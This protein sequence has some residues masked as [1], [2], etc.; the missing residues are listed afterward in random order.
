MP[1]EPAGAPRSW[2]PGAGRVV[3]GSTEGK[4]R[5][6]GGTP[7]T[8]RSVVRSRG[9]RVVLGLT[10]I[11]LIYIVLIQVLFW[12]QP[13]RPPNLIVFQAG[14]EAELAVD[15]NA[16]GLNAAASLLAEIRRPAANLA[17]RK[18]WF[19][20]STGFAPKVE[21]RQLDPPFVPTTAIPA[22]SLASGGSTILYITARVGT[23]EGRPYLL[24]Q[25][26]LD[27]NLR[28]TGL[29]SHI[30]FAE[31][32][33]ILEDLGVQKNHRF[34]LVLDVAPASV[35]DS[36]PLVDLHALASLERL[37]PGPHLVVILPKDARGT[38]VDVRWRQSVFGHHAIQGLLGAATGANHRLTPAKLAQ[39]I[40]AQINPTAAARSVGSV[41]IL[42]TPEAIHTDILLMS[43]SRGPRISESRLAV[44]AVWQ[45]QIQSTWKSYQALETGLNPSPRAFA[46]QLWRRYRELLLRSDSLI[47][48][49]DPATRDDEATKALLASFR[50]ALVATEATLKRRQSI[51]WGDSARQTLAMSAVDATA[52]S[53]PSRISLAE[54]DQLWTDSKVKAIDFP[55]AAVPSIYERLLDKV[56]QA[57][58][59]SDYRTAD[60][61]LAKFSESYAPRPVEGHLLALLLRDQWPTASDQVDYR[62]AVHAV[63]QVRRMAE[64]AAVGLAP[65]PETG[66]TAV[67][68]SASAGN[69]LPERVAPWVTML[70]EAGDL[71]QRQAEDC[72]L[73]S[74]PQEW[75]Q[76]EDLAG[77]ARARY[78]TALDHVEL[79]T[80]AFAARDRAFDELPFDSAWMM[81]MPVEGKSSTNQRGQRWVEVLETAWTHAHALANQLAVDAPLS[82]QSIDWEPTQ[83]AVLEAQVQDDLTAIRGEMA[84]IE[85]RVRD[86]L[87]SVGRTATNPSPTEPLDDLGPLIQALLATPFVRVDDRPALAEAAVRWYEQPRPGGSILPEDEEWIVARR[88]ARMALA[89][90][91]S[92]R[93]EQP[94]EVKPLASIGE[95]RSSKPSAEPPRGFAVVRDR[96]ASLDAGLAVDGTETSRYLTCINQIAQ[97]QENLP[98]RIQQ[99]LTKT[100][101]ITSEQWLTKAHEADMTGRLILGSQEIKDDPTLIER[102]RLCQR[103][104]TVQADRSFDDHYYSAAP[105]VDAALPE[106]PLRP[107]H[108]FF[109]R[110]INAYHATFR[111]LD[112]RYKGLASDNEQSTE[113]APFQQEMIDLRSKAAQPGRLTIDLASPAAPLVVTDAPTLSLHYRVQSRASGQPVAGSPVFWL[114]LDSAAS[115]RASLGA[116]AGR[117]LIK[118]DVVEP[119]PVDSRVGAAPRSPVLATFDP[120]IELPGVVPGATDGAKGTELRPGSPA[121]AIRLNGRFRGQVL[122][123]ETPIAIHPTPEI[124]VTSDPPPPTASI[125]VRADAELLRRYGRSEGGALAIILDCSGSM[126]PPPGSP[127][128]SPSKFREVTKAV[129]QLL[130]RLARGTQVSVYIFGQEILSATA[131]QPSAEETITRIVDPTLWNPDD[132]T[133][134]RS[135]M[136]R[137]EGPGFRPFNSS[138]IVKAML[139]VKADL[140]RTAGFKSIL[141]LTDGKDTSF[142]L[143]D[144]KPIISGGEVAAVLRDNFAAS[145][146]E[147]NVVGF[148][149][150]DSDDEIRKQFG[151]IETFPHRGHFFLASNAASLANALNQALRPSLSYWL[152]T[153]DQSR[154]IGPIPLVDSPD[155]L[156]AI[157]VEPGSYRLVVDAGPRQEAILH[158]DSGDNLPVSLTL[159][160]GQIRIDRLIWTDG[161]IPRPIER[162]VKTRQA[163]W[164]AS[165]LQ[166]QTL[167]ED[168][169]ELQTSIELRPNRREQDLARGRAPRE[170]ALARPQAVWMEINPPKQ[171]K[172][173]MTQRWAPRFD[174]MAPTWGATVTHWPSEERPTFQTWWAIDNLVPIDRIARGPD[175]PPIDQYRNLGTAIK[176]VVIESVTVER[177][178]IERRH[179]LPDDQSFLIIR[180]KYPP[181]EPYWVEL[182]GL[183]PIP[184]EHRFYRQVQRYTGI[185]GP[186][187]D[188][189]AGPVTGLAIHSVGQFKQRAT[190]LGLT[191]TEPIEL[192][193]STAST[194]PLPMRFDDRT[195]LQPLS[196]STLP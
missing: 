66:G 26:E 146:V 74:S 192:T 106:D 39:Y 175:F 129:A 48:Q 162:V 189:M 50:D 170:V 69:S 18:G 95:L 88:A 182:M 147:I 123:R 148:K 56:Q 103:L 40:E 32:I 132:P 195:D 169:V 116:D 110:A 89:A 133:V 42:G 112:Q 30:Q 68:A 100:A 125:A 4:W 54:F 27:K 115:L 145:D 45:Q 14:Y 176:G 35:S 92:K 73:G 121:P 86:Q 47:Q 138:P 61:I 185:F 65:R 179:D 91:G 113:P 84:E 52:I 114:D 67:V 187:N 75:Q 130:P 59:A 154:S 98:E 150:V 122:R 153:L 166:D 137:I 85:R 124:V 190:K 184:V 20:T 180:L 6:G 97:V 63:L 93:F 9:I 62:R 15:S 1:N 29:P 141:I 64:Q 72:L 196:D 44:P 51:P 127:P 10:G 140:P 99:N 49:I 171:V 79:V 183:G 155:A 53:G 194:A 107:E 58:S 161:L 158:V 19:T 134:L 186:W 22:G 135:V 128:E 143:A 71:L 118:L 181:G 12:F 193:P 167:G 11:T 165:V 21:V 43:E 38:A 111:E 28:P 105:V 23:E 24:T 168:R 41:A 163:E 117:S 83:L 2:R 164:K 77:A 104:L 126:G 96:L 3:R 8:A 142:E 82:R 70:V 7:Q 5:R 17:A 81:R 90:I 109:Q 102:G 87:G 173:A 55:I 34:C 101:G 57:E 136:S 13:V 178:P 31:L 108:P 94:R 46:P 172:S 60:Q 139:K 78:Q 25:T 119:A 177:A 191:M 76:A 36:S 156:T 149:V 16:H 37:K 120:L 188:A 151:I 144:A 159:H 131:T 80:A 33:N 174:Q 157:A 152:Q 160:G